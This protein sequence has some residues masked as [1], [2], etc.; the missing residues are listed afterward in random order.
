MYER[1]GEKKGLALTFTGSNEALYIP[2]FAN[3]ERCSGLKTLIKLT[4]WLKKKNSDG[5]PKPEKSLM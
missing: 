3:S 4:L 2:A 1:F 5:F